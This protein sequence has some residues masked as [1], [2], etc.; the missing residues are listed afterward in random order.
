VDSII[1][2]YKNTTSKIKIA[3]NWQVFFQSTSSST[4]KD[5]KEDACPIAA[6][7]L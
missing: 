7:V 4:G 3:D 1:L 6:C 2:D 5:G